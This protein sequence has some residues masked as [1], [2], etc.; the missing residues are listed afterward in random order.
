MQTQLKGG[1][2]GTLRLREP[3]SKLGEDPA[4]IRRGEG[5]Q[6][7]RCRDPREKTL[8][9]P[10]DCKE[11]QPVH[12]EG[13]QPW[14]FFGVGT[15]DPELWSSP[16]PTMAMSSPLSFHTVSDLTPESVG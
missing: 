1:N 10:L 7:K 14:D 13:D 9:S 15:M 11:I 4:M 12:S 16:A 5:A 6:R 2:K 3:G 8:E